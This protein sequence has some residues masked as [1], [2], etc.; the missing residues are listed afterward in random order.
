MIHTHMQWCMLNN[1]WLRNV[2]ILT[3][4]LIPTML[5]KFKLELLFSASTQHITIYM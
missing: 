1:K 4:N 5:A 3:A 2:Q